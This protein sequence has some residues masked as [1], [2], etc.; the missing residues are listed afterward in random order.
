MPLA[1]SLCFTVC[2][3]LGISS[4]FSAHADN[5]AYVDLMAKD[6]F[7]NALP[8]PQAERAEAATAK[9]YNSLDDEA[10]ASFRDARRARWRAMSADER[11]ALRNVKEPAFEN[12]TDDQQEVYRTIATD[13]L[14]GRQAK[15]DDGI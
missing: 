11:N 6:Y 8:R 2:L 4:S 14:G 7:E 3:S 5:D 9:F 1:R 13:H 10:K 15:P 12:L